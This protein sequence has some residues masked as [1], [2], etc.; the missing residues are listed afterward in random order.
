MFMPN[1]KRANPPN[2][3]TKSSQVIFY[4]TPEKVVFTKIIRLIIWSRPFW[5]PD[6]YRGVYLAV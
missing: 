4:D 3:L 2:R 5:L 1:R 6:L